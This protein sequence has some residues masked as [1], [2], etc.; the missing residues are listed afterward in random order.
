MSEILTLKS[1][2]AHV[3]VA[4]DDDGQGPR[5]RVRDHRGGR[6][7][8]LDPLELE[9]LTRADTTQLDRY[10]PYEDRDAEPWAA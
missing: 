10:L 4:I 3:T 7:R 8:L 2:F 1:E 9:C 6:E 5:L